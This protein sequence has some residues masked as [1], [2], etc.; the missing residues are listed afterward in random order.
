[1][2]T[3]PQDSTSQPTATEP[4]EDDLRLKFREAL[5]RKHGGGPGVGGSAGA[6]NKASGATTNNKVQR[7][8]RR[9]SG[10]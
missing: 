5:A 3:N 7:E 1:M 2:A 6:G 9:K 8:F 4:A 10:G